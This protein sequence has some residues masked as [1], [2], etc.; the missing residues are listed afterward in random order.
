MKGLLLKELYT[1]KR[2]Y[3]IYFAFQAF[4][5]IIFTLSGQEFVMYW[6]FC[7][8]LMWSCMLI[9]LFG[10]DDKSGW[11]RYIGVL[12]YSKAQI[13]SARYIIST[14][15]QLAFFSQLAVAQAVVMKLEGAFS[16]GEY[17]MY[18]S[19]L[20]FLNSV[21][22]GLYPVRFRF[23]ERGLKIIAVVF[24]LII[25]TFFIITNIV[26]RAEITITGLKSAITVSLFCI[27]AAAIYVLSWYLSI[28][29]YKKR[30]L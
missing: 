19:I 30:E 5:L 9:A 12:P 18:L 10:E 6:S 29:F 21:V 27:A 25:T 11:S 26:I 4:F 20:F 28:V 15:V 24:V 2:N 8:S 3:K 16:F 23:G 13:V 14:F 17:L 1:F 22:Y 7:I